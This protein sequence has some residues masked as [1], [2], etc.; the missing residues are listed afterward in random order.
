MIKIDEN[1]LERVDKILKG[2][3]NVAKDIKLRAVRRAALAAK[4]EAT[5]QGRSRYNLKSEEINKTFEFTQP[6]K[7]NIS[8]TLVSTGERIRL[9]KFKVS[10][11][12][13]PKKR[14]V[15]KVSVIKGQGMKTL[16]TAFVNKM[17]N[18]TIGVFQRAGRQRLPITQLY[19]P[20]VP[21]LFR[22]P[23]VKAAIEKKAIDVLENRIS[24]ELQRYIGD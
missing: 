22:E 1:G 23:T 24:H 10:P 13:V 5:R 7:N 12:S 21:Q 11:A 6:N 8:A 3:P 15:V 14:R 17:P 2:L 9:I 20:S 16:K 4:A 18:G 19:G